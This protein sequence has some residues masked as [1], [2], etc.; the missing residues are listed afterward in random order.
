MKKA[1]KIDYLTEMRKQRV[2]QSKSV[3]NSPGNKL[4]F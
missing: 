3:T 1:T 4:K 2:E